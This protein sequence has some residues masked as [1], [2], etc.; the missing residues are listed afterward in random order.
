MKNISRI[1]SVCLCSASL[2]AFDAFGVVA[3]NSGSNLTSYNPSNAY[4]NQWSTLTNA[5]YNDNGF[6]SAKA[7]F[8]NCD[9]LILRCAQP[10]CSNGGCTDKDVAKAIV[11]GCVLANAKCKKYG[12]NLIESITGQVIASSQAKVNTANAEQ[13]AAAQAA[14]EQAQAAAQQATAAQQQ[15]IAEMQSN[16]QQQMLE[17]QQRMADQ[18]AESARQIADALEK[19]QQQQKAAIS[20]M[21]S[22]A[23]ASAQV[24]ITGGQTI[25]PA[26]QEAIQRNVDNEIIERNKIGPQILSEIEGAKTALK[27]ARAAMDAAFDY[28]KCDTRGDGCNMPKRIKKWRE[29]ASGFIEP[30]DTV[31]DQIL[32][33]LQ[34]AQLVGIDV[35]EIYMMLNDSCNTWG[36]YLCAYK[37]DSKEAIIRY[38]PRYST[39]GEQKPN[40]G[41]PRVCRKATGDEDR[42]SDGWQKWEL[43]EQC[44]LLKLLTDKKEVYEGWVNTDNETSSNQRVIAC[45]SGALDKSPLFAH[46]L[47]TQSGA[48]IVDIDKLAQWINQREPG[49]ATPETAFPYCEKGDIK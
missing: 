10:K 36:E 12:D 2:F 43:C 40:K 18:N 46:K 22:A 29:L 21:K 16:M 33:A 17:L 14:A 38:N 3:T 44:T 9:A 15:Q 13:I 1:F 26:V 30:Y 45:A 41:E 25:T 6:F 48:G 4:N 35:S 32:I 34:T 42:D 31:A 5:R 37:G 39:S 8:G 28:A 24:Q 20:E 7:N 11:K 27:A 23:Q 47:K 49:S 19:S